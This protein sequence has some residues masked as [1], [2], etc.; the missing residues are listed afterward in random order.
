MKIAKVYE[1]WRNKLIP[2]NHLKL[3]ILEVAE[4]RMDICNEC[5]WNSSNRKNYVSVRPDIH[6]IDCGCTLSA[7]VKCLSCACG[8]GFWKAELTEEQDANI[9]SYGYRD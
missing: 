3:K 7:K 8:K 2:P 1:G 5:F 4:A 6:C 9:E